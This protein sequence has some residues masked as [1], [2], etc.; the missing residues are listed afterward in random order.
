MS[1]TKRLLA[2]LNAARGLAYPDVGY[3]YFAGVTGAGGKYRP[4]VYTIIN[5]GG[6]VTYSDLNDVSARKRCDKIRAAIETAKRDM[7]GVTL[8]HNPARPWFPHEERKDNV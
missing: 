2:E 1:T 5:A 4:S 6:G 8:A 3:T 7:D